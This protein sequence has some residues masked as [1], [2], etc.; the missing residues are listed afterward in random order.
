MLRRTVLMILLVLLPAVLFAQMSS[1]ADQLREGLQLF[2][3][4]RYREAIRV[5]R[6]IIANAERERIQGNAPDAYYW[7]S[8][9]FLAMDNYEQAAISLEYYLSNYPYHSYAGDALY[10]KGR[11]L[12]LQGEPENALQVLELFVREYPDS[13]YVGNAYFWIGESLFSLGHLEEAA[14]VFNKVIAEYS[15]SA[16]TEAAGYRLSMIEFKK[17]EDELLDILKWSHEEA[18]NSIEQLERRERAYEEAIEAYQRKLSSTTP[19]AEAAGNMAELEQLKNA[20]EELRRQ[21]TD[22]QTQLALQSQESA[23]GAA[24]LEQLRSANEDLRGQITALETQL[25]SQ[26]EASADAASAAATRRMQALENRAKALQLKEDALAVK[27]SLLRRLS[28]GSE[29]GQ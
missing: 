12:Y 3:E 24:E 29:E 28:G 23:N 7:M 27:E 9:A 4:E 17:R 16:K 25:A 13:E 19:A 26:S 20:N 11:L 18:L 1:G 22:L 5:F 14:R 2:K 6:G 8:R 21:I 10:Q 15:T